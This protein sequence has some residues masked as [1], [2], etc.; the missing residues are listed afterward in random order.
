MVDTSLDNRVEWNVDYFFVGQMIS[1]HS[2]SLKETKKTGG[3]KTG[4]LERQEVFQL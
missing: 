2:I 1:S 4:G 3:D